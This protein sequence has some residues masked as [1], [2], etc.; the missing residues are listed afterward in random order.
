MVA[1]FL[2]PNQELREVLQRAHESECA[3]NIQT[4][5]VTAD[6]TLCCSH[7]S[8]VVDFILRNPS[9]ESG[10]LQMSGASFFEMP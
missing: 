4:S 9:D 5:Q 8:A 7:N 3:N 6:L 2:L 10:T 1:A